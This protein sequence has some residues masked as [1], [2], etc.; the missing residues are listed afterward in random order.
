MP[1]TKGQLCHI[2]SPTGLCAQTWICLG[3]MHFLALL[4]ESLL[5]CTVCAGN[6]THFS[7]RSSTFLTQKQ[8]AAR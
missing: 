5:L 8:T 7:W 2:L 3:S 4:T 6:K 1:M